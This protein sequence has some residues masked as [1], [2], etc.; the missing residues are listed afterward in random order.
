MGRNEI[1]TTIEVKLLTALT[2]EQLLEQA[3]AGDEE[4]FTALYRRRQGPIFRF[5]LHMSGSTQIAEEVTQDVFIFLLQRGSDFDPARGALGA[6]LF[7]VARNY[8]RR[9][10]ERS[11]ADN[12]LSSPVEDEAPA[13]MVQSDPGEGISRHQTSIAVWKAVLSLPEHYR[14]VVVLCDLQE[15]SYAQ[16]AESMGCAIGTIR[17]RL[18]R[19]HDMLGKKLQRSAAVAP[20]ISGIAARCVS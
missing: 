11:Y 5:A 8:V 2:D 1:R 12:V 17:S 13:L 14:E 9:A 20:G 3:L 10:L 7:G 19:A 6:Y 4:A 15:L 18:H 16:A